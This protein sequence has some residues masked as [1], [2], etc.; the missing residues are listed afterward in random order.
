MKIT[1][2]VISVEQAYKHGG[3]EMRN[4]KIRLWGGG[5]LTMKVKPHEARA[6]RIGR[7]ITVRI[8]PD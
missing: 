7:N 8:K 4:V 2:E 1:G 3:D 5:E 6:Y